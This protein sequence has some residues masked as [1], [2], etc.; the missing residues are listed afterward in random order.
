MQHFFI[1]KYLIEYNRHFFL[2]IFFVNTF[3]LPYQ[4]YDIRQELFDK[5]SIIS[6][7]PST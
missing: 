4:S 5:P 3:E 7:F 6:F 1:D 2:Y